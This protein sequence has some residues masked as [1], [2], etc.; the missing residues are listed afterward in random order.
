[1]QLEQRAEE[2]SLS[3]L[4]LLVYVRR[5]ELKDRLE[6]CIFDLLEEVAMKNLD[7]ALRTLSKMRYLVQFG[8]I[9]YEVE[10]M[11]SAAIIDNISTFYYEIEQ[12]SGF[13]VARGIGNEGPRVIV[14][15]KTRGD[16]QLSKR[17]EKPIKHESGNQGSD[18][19]N[20]KEIRQNV[21]KKESL[22]D[23]SLEEKEEVDNSEIRQTAIIGKIRQSGN[24]EVLSKDLVSSF[25]D[26]S[27][28]TIRYDLQKLCR[29]GIIVRIGAG[30]PNTSYQLRV[31]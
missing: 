8:G 17:Q 16:M 15:S 30:G 22:L 5:S 2:L 9:I 10:P 25:P 27:P 24:K 13:I 31:L 4:R 14:D 11:T 3:I 18:A 28:R 26:I 12:T 21:E 1:M 20:H 29:Q 7:G 19:L 23:K 6:R